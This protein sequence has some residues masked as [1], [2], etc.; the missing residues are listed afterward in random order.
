MKEKNMA[1]QFSNPFSR[2]KPTAEEKA[3]LTK[4]GYFGPGGMK[5]DTLDPLISTISQSDT[6]EYRVL[7]P[8][9]R[10]GKIDAFGRPVAQTFTNRQQAEN[11]VRSIQNRQ[12]IEKGLAGTT[13]TDTTGL[14]GAEFRTAEQRRAEAEL[15]KQLG[16]ERLAD[17][18]PPAKLEAAKMETV[19]VAEQQDQFLDTASKLLGE[20]AQADISRAAPAVEVEAPAPLVAPTGTA[21]VRAGQEQDVTAAQKA[22]PSQTVGDIQGAV[23]AEAVAAAAQADL[24]PKATVRYQLEQL[25][26]G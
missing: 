9:G 23:S 19:D 6:P 18:K 22:A 24:D 11:Y 3:Q 7:D 10:I 15:A 14:T 13:P 21:A 5:G 8:L 26:E 25:Y 20:A 16:V 17:V 1:Q 12:A 2:W 4:Q